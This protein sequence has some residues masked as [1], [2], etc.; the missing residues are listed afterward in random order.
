MVYTIIAITMMVSH[1]CILGMTSCS[2]KMVGC[3]MCEGCMM[4][5][6]TSQARLQFTGMQVVLQ[7][8]GPPGPF[9]HLLLRTREVPAPVLCIVPGPAERQSG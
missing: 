6:P 4:L 9:L 5:T 1:E 7:F 8:A 2:L 3:D